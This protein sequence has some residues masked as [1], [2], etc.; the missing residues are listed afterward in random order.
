MIRGGIGR[1]VI[2]HEGNRRRDST[3]CRITDIIENTNQSRS[4]ETISSR[5][6]RIVTLELDRPATFCLRTW[7]PHTLLCRGHSV[8]AGELQAAQGLGSYALLLP[9]I[10]E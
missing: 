2:L 6:L 9:C 8:L 7:Q 5:K 1:L 4:L 10:A 3:S